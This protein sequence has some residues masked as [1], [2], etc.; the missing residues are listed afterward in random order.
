MTAKRRGTKAGAADPE[1]PSP[2]RR[3]TLYLRGELYD[4]A[5]AAILDLGAQGLEPASISS[6]L[7]EALD[8]ELKRLAKKHRNGKPW[9]LHKG[10]LPGGRPAG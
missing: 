5:R 10:R 8:R 3:T 7:D 4:Q 9:G 6:L 2:R 1:K